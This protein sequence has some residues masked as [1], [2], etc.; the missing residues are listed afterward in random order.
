MH[1]NLPTTRSV[2]IDAIPNYQSIDEGRSAE[3]K[4]L[5]G[6]AIITNPKARAL[7]S[8]QL[9]TEVQAFQ[10]VFDAIL[11]QIHAYIDELISLNPELKEAELMLYN[12]DGGSFEERI[13]NALK[14]NGVSYD[15]EISEHSPRNEL[16]D[17]TKPAGS[18][19]LF[20]SNPDEN[21]DLPNNIYIRFGR[22]YKLDTVKDTEFE[23]LIQDDQAREISFSNQA[24]FKDLGFVGLI[25]EGLEKIANGE[26]LSPEEINVLASMLEIH[27]M[28][29]GEFK[30]E[31]LLPPDS[32][33]HPKHMVGSYSDSGTS[34]HLIPEYF[35]ASRGQEFDAN[36][37]NNI[38]LEP[39]D[40]GGHHQRP[41]AALEVLFA[42]RQEFIDDPRYLEQNQLTK[43]RLSNAWFREHS[44]AM[45]EH[46][47][48]GQSGSPDTNYHYI[49][50]VSS[51]HF[52]YSVVRDWL[53]DEDIALIYREDLACK[54]PLVALPEILKDLEAIPSDEHG[55]DRIKIMKI[56]AGQ[57]RILGPQRFAELETKLKNQEIIDALRDEVNEN[58]TSPPLVQD[59][60]DADF[61]EKLG[62]TVPE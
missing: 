8:Q 18:I 28:H 27:L 22:T 2:Q 11:P 55:T 14:I 20:R 7:C 62:L 39:E 41:A 40:H 1:L 57:F 42:N 49:A 37:Q 43:F 59:L 24:D 48:A 12:C 33:K 26:K 61:I 50:N 5:K 13:K 6:Q 30:L 60:N 19:S 38:W 21:Q 16:D 32:I 23:I 51:R 44:A 54:T 31:G 56:L 52:N 4:A 15:L 36:R 10:R 17:E 45:K 3:L 47:L 58:Q 35:L 34:T 29:S 25:H 53:F 46:C 9:E